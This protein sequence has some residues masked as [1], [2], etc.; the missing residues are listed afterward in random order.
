MVSFRLTFFIFSKR[1]EM[2]ALMHTRCFFM[3]LSRGSKVKR[4]ILVDL[5]SGWVAFWTPPYY[6]SSR[7]KRFYKN[8]WR[9]E[10]NGSNWVFSAESTTVWPLIKQL[11]GNS[12]HKIKNEEN[13]ALKKERLFSNSWNFVMLLTPEQKF[14]GIILKAYFPSY[15]PLIHASL[16]VVRRK[17]K[18][19]FFTLR[20]EII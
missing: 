17:T 13:F 16:Q 14:W 1:W 7:Q 9:Q 19:H 12:L 4:E 2:Y 6:I 10:N 18:F 3:F 5:L 20:H 11:F 15:W 8:P